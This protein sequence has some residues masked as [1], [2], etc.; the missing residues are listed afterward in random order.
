[1]DDGELVSCD[2]ALARRFKAASI[3]D[4]TA[5]DEILGSTVIRSLTPVTPINWRTAE[6]AAC[7]S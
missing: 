3:S 1:V 7:L 2:S 5:L 4:R 6:A